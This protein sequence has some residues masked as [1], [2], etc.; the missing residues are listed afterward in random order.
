MSTSNCKKIQLVPS[1]AN[2][3]SVMREIGSKE[4]TNKTIYGGSATSQEGAQRGGRDLDNKGLR[5]RGMM[6]YG[7]D[8]RDPML[9]MW[10]RSR[11]KSEL[12]MPDGL[13]SDMHPED[14][15]MQRPWK[16]H[17]FLR[18][19]NQDSRQ[20]DVVIVVENIS[21]NVSVSVGNVFM[22]RFSP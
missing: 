6:R 8:M 7:G 14:Y 16:L 20:L 21:R 1:Q 2:I 11:G 10:I 4:K 22:L 12:G 9:S 19:F 18:A 17:I 5:N 13:D 15:G 3:H